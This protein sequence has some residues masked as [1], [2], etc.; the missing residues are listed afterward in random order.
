MGTIL[1]LNNFINTKINSLSDDDE[2]DDDG[3]PPINCNYYDINE[4]TKAKFNASKSFSILHINIHS[5]NKHI[6]ELRIIRNLLNF[7]FDVIAL[8]V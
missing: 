3:T 6:E 2:G 1:N 7:K 8:S 5:V 4:F